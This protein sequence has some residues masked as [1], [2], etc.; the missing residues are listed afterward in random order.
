MYCVW[1]NLVRSTAPLYFVSRSKFEYLLNYTPE[2]LPRYN[3]FSG[4]PLPYLETP[5]PLASRPSSRSKGVIMSMLAAVLDES[6]NP[7][8]LLFMECNN[9]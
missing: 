5:H 7:L 2:R 9:T 8:M 6:R 3:L 1:S 4:P